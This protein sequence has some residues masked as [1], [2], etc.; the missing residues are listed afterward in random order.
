MWQ[1]I[2]HQTSGGRHDEE[3]DVWTRNRDELKLWR[4]ID[5]I[6]WSLQV[7]WHL[8][9]PAIE[10][11]ISYI[12]F[13]NRTLKMKFVLRWLCDRYMIFAFFGVFRSNLQSYCN[14]YWNFISASVI[15][16]V[17][18]HLV[19][20]FRSVRCSL[21][22]LCARSMW[23]REGA[24]RLFV[25]HVTLFNDEDDNTCSSESVVRLWKVQCFVMYK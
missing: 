16:R 22:F 10:G 20:L 23:Q 4:E 8:F 9:S 11:R 13:C 2:V 18:I 19:E 15:L 12:Y 5:S 17:F 21:Y 14:K 25:E 7:I 3:R 24:V 1:S 6:A